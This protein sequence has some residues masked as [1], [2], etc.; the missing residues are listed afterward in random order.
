VRILLQE[1]GTASEYG[2]LVRE[3][4]KRWVLILPD[5]SESYFHIWAEGE[6]EEEA[7]FHLKEK[8]DKVQMLISAQ[9]TPL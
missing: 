2:I 8:R 3:H 7:E 9:S 1:L 4:S 6:T 5:V